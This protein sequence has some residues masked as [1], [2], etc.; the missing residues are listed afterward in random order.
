MSRN[1]LHMFGL[2]VLGVTHGLPCIAC[3]V[4][5]FVKIADDSTQRQ[6]DVA[7]LSVDKTSLCGHASSTLEACLMGGTCKRLAFVSVLHALVC[8]RWYCDT[9]VGWAGNFLNCQQSVLSLLLAL[10]YDIVLDRSNRDADVTSQP[11]RGVK[12]YP[13]CRSHFVSQATVSTMYSYTSV[14]AYSVRD[15]VSISLYTKLAYTKPL[16]KVN[17]ITAAK[18]HVYILTQTSSYTSYKGNQL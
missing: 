12:S 13:R 16:F 10:R 18:L 4:P 1:I 9:L 3:G 5:P 14:L 17:G 6:P 8:T 11:D 2:C 7:K 15:T